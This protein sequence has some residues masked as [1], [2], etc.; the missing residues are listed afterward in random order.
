MGEGLIRGFTVGHLQVS[1]LLFADDML[2]LNDA[3]DG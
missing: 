3:D 1:Q 2:I